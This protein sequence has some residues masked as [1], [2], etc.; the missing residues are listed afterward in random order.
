MTSTRH[1]RRDNWLPNIFVREGA[2]PGQDFS[3]ED[4]ADSTRR[5]ERK[6]ATDS[7]NFSTAKSK[8]PLVQARR[9]LAGH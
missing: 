4:K 2:E 7:L 5:K 6:K 1:Y 9:L 8:R 3:G